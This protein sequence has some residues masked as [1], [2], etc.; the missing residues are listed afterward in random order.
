MDAEREQKLQ[1]LHIYSKRNLLYPDQFDLSLS[2]EEKQIYD[3]CKVFALFHSKEKHKELIPKAIEEHRILE[4]IQDL[5]EARAAG[6]T[7]TTKFNRFIEEKRKKKA[8]FFLLQLNHGGQGNVAGKALKSPRGL[9]RNLQSFGSDSL[10]KATFPI[11]CSS[12]DNW[13]VSGLLGAD[14]LSE[15]EKKMC[16]EMRILPAHY[17]K[18]LETLKSEIKKKSDAYS[19]FRVEPSQVDKVYDLLKQKI[20]QS[21]ISIID[22]LPIMMN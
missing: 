15:T 22:Q 21:S 3:K 8:E 2:A 7:T 4:R 16:N 20:F 11:I 17:F 19:F 5:Q 10:S 18:I 13:G 14:L 6:C 9:Q 12:L 1:I